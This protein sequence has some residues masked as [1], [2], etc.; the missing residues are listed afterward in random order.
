MVGRIF[1]AINCVCGGRNINNQED[2]GIIL[3]LGI[4]G[5]EFSFHKVT[6]CLSFPD[7]RKS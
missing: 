5:S 2:R 7:P 4:W 6:E 3:I 1:F